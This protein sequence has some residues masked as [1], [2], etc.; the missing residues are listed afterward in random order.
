M[1]IN[2]DRLRN[3]TSGTALGLLGPYPKSNTFKHV[4]VMQEILAFLQADFRNA[5]M[6]K[7][8]PSP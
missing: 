8:W 3:A 6:A 5:R 7:R 4:I 2:T 1:N